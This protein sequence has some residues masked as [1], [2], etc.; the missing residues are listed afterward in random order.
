MKEVI[1]PYE[2]L[3]RKYINLFGP[4]SIPFAKDVLSK[5]LVSMNYCIRDVFT[6]R[7]LHA[8]T[9]LLTLITNFRLTLVNFR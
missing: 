3:T 5:L 8:V 2:Q 9:D 4:N 7:S 6:K 1:L